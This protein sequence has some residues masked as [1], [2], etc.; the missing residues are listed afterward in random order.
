[1]WQTGKLLL[2]IQMFKLELR[3][4]IDEN[5]KV[6]FAHLASH[7]ILLCFMEVKVE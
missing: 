3:I 2:V 1:M 5:M 4:V 6:S 7:F